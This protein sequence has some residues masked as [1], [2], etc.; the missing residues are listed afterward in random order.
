MYVKRAQNPHRVRLPPIYTVRICR[1]SVHLVSCSLHMLLCLTYYKRSRL[2]A[3]RLAPFLINKPAAGSARR[4][5]STARRETP[6]SGSI[7]SER[8]AK[9]YQCG[10]K[11][12]DDMELLHYYKWSETVRARHFD[13]DEEC[14]F[15][16]CFLDRKRK[17]MDF[18]LPAF[19]KIVGNPA[20]GYKT[21]PAGA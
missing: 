21:H 13:L 8:D 1:R 3:S 5:R 4:L 19:R 18:D 17:H 9:F 6:R 7:R 11:A 2:Y 14:L 15:I 16:H 20:T 10:E 12:I